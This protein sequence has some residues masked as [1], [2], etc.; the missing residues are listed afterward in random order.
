[1]MYVTFPKADPGDMPRHTMRIVTDGEEGTQVFPA[2]GVILKEKENAVVI[3][4]IIEME[5]TA[6][7]G[8]DVRKGD[9][10][11]SINGKRVSTLGS[12]SA[13]FD[14]I[15]IGDR[16]TWQIER[17]GARKEV[18]FARPKPMGRVMIKRKP[19]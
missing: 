14:A 15:E 5:N 2:V 13:I 6:V 8:L 18:S 12:Y 9:T 10:I 4:D 7:K 19:E 17:K 3:Q 1:M 11:R 16:V